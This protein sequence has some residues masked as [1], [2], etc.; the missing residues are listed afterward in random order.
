MRKAIFIA[1]FDSQLKWCGPIREEFLKRGYICRTVVP[2]IRSALS[3]E[4]I[5]TAGFESVEKLSWDEMREAAKSHDIIVS[6]LAGPLLRRLTFELSQ[7]DEGPTKPILVSG[8]VGIIIEKLVAGYLDRAGCDVVA[9]NSIEDLSRFKRAADYLN[10]PT[11]NLNLTGLSLLPPM[12]APQTSKT[13]QKVLFA[14][15][16]TIPTSSSE[17]LYLYKK[18]NEYAEMHPE[19]EVLLKP[20]H[21]LGEDTFHKMKFHP[22]TLLQGRTLAP[23]F[24]IDYQ[25][26]TEAIKSIDLLITMS[27]T[28]S[29]E[30]LSAGIK[31]AFP[32]DFGVH[33]RYGN[34]VFLHSGLLRTFAQ[35]GR[36]EIGEP[37]AEWLR[38]YFFGRQKTAFEAIADR[39]EELLV[40]GER[41]SL[42]VWNSEYFKAMRETHLNLQTVASK[43]RV[44]WKRKLNKLRTQPSL[45][46]SDAV[47]KHKLRIK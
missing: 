41:P 20:R 23:N 3:E 26:I 4:Q 24:R 39:C 45:F 43:P 28:A 22:E 44:R 35:I 21:R 14:D 40:S 34:Q 10:L 11:D 6:A 13:I 17:R 36:D 25:P 7:T 42:G 2:G 19:R 8:W 47:K 46:L 16:P 9:V 5:A 15:Q 32:M 27:S 18:I 31:V 37:D 33:E 30:A 29:L 12:A 1:T 38:S